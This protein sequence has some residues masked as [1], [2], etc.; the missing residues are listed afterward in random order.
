MSDTPLEPFD[1]ANPAHQEELAQLR[2]S[3]LERDLSFAEK[4]EFELPALSVMHSDRSIGIWLFDAPFT[5]CLSQALASTLGGGKHVVQVLFTF[6]AW[7]SV[8][9]DGNPPISPPSADPNRKEGLLF[10]NFW[11]SEDGSIKFEP[12]TYLISGEAPSRTLTPYSRE[13]KGSFSG[14][15]YDRLRTFLELTRVPLHKSTTTS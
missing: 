12:S 5:N 14:N 13:D 7:V 9:I 15:F 1:Y 4:G 3:I 8:G 6:E 11:I 10:M 2:K